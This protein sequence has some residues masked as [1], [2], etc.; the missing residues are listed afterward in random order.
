M[1]SLYEHPDFT[2]NRGNRAIE[3]DS[4]KLRKALQI[5]DGLFIESNLSAN[6]IRDVIQRLLQQ[7]QIPIEHMRVYLRQDRDAKG[8]L[9]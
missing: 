1:R 8:S 7:Y 3:H 5:A 4:A 2:S 6:S 9:P